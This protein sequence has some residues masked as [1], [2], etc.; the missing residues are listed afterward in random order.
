M[1]TESTLLT[2]EA[3]RVIAL[4]MQV[5]MLGGAGALQE[6]DLMVKEKTTAFNKA[7]VDLSNGV[8][9]SSVKK[10]VSLSQLK[11]RSTLALRAEVGCR[12]ASVASI[13]ALDDDCE[14]CWTIEGIVPGEARQLDIDQARGAVLARLRS[15]YRLLSGQRPFRERND[16]QRHLI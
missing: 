16:D 15:E 13:R 2:M 4:R 14:G 1:M 7:M 6:A 11:L 9:Q 10:A 3:S 12:T 8:P 5:F